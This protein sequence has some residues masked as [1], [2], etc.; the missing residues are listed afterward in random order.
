MSS[1][2]L[3]TQIMM[4]L[5]RTCLVCKEKFTLQKSLG[6]W[7]C[8][9][10]P[11]VFDYD[12]NGKT[13]ATCCGEPANYGGCRRHDHVD[14]K[15]LTHFTDKYPLTVAHFTS[16]YPFTKDLQRI[17]KDRRDNGLT[18]KVIDDKKRLTNVIDEHNSIILV[19]VHP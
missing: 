11:G 10:H 6:R 1:V 18:V 3:D 12:K 2:D 4:G 9:Y 13:I 14:G 5:E 19:K 17:H 8:G 15:V 7:Q 16:E